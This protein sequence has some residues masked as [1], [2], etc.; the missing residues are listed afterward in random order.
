MVGW[1]KLKLGRQTGF[2]PGHIV[3]DG[4]PAPPPLKEHSPPPNFSPIYVV[5][6]WLDGSRCHLVGTWE[7]GFG[8]SDIMLDGDPVLPPKKGGR[9]LPIFGPCL[10]CPNGWMD[11][12]GT[13]HGGMP[14]PRPHFARLGPSSPSPKTGY[15]PSPHFSAHVYCGQ[16]AGWI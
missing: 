14:L 12:D 16:T 10:L 15:N 1:I 9:A 4:G 6:K 2:G 13:W 3:L 8:P 5:A 7:V 11:Q